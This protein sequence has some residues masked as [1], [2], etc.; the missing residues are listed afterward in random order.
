ML[1]ELVDA[2]RILSVTHLSRD[3]NL[4]VFHK[5]AK[6]IHANQG[7][8]DQ[9]ISLNPQLVITDAETDH[10]AKRLLKTF[11]I[12]VLVF[13]H[14]N[15]L[16][17][18]FSNLRGLAVSLNVAPR[19]EE[20]IWQIEHDLPRPFGDQP[21]RALIYQPNGFA[22]G[23]SSLMGDIVDRA[24]YFNAARELG[25][26]YGGFISL[27]SLLLLDPDILIFSERQNALPS[28]SETALSHPALKY[29]GHEYDDNDQRF[30]VSVPENLWTC[31]G[32][33]NQKAIEILRY[34]QK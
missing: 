6:K 33:F 1:F 19:A 9:I 10:L 32:Q 12:R 23:P 18:Y 26:I 28:L 31:A 17:D 15:N 16:E 2:T 13:P 11:G 30:R 8:V 4:S 7:N 24:G 5:E 14:A 22:P 25:F 3:P 27:E 20:I 21:V 29:F 34:I